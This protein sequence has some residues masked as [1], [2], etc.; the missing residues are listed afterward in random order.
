MKSTKLKALTWACLLALV[1]GA[2]GVAWADAVVTFSG[3][4]EPANIDVLIWPAE[5]SMRLS[6]GQWY[7]AGG[8]TVENRSLIPVR[9]AAFFMPNFSAFPGGTVDPWMF[10]DLDQEK[11]IGNYT[12]DAPRRFGFLIS[13]VDPLL[14][15][16]YALPDN[17]AMALG[18]RVWGSGM[19]ENAVLYYDSVANRTEVNGTPIKP[20]KWWIREAWGIGVSHD[21]G[22]IRENSQYTFKYTMYFDPRRP[23]TKD[24]GTNYL[25]L[26]FS[27]IES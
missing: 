26:T 6:P 22:A 8:I 16:V 9:V 18:F 1:L 7:S 14:P 5:I 27:A 17:W 13:C 12:S 10:F 2:A 20:S 24:I 25:I 11:P 15:Q 21:L 23:Q 4:L 19:F 3:I